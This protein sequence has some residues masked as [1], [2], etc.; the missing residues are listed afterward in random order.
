MADWNS[1]EALLMKQLGTK[2][3]WGGQAPGGFDCS[4][5][6]QWAY[7][8]NGIGL[9]RTTYNQINIGAS[10]DIGNLQPGDLVFFDTE[11]QNAGPDHV[12]IYI[13]GGKFIHAPHTGDVVKISSLADPYYQNRFFAGRRIPG[14]TGA[15]PADTAALTT[16]PQAQSTKLDAATLAQEYGLS[17]ALLTSDSGL[18]NLFNEAVAN[19]WTPDV[20]TAK[21]KESNWWKSNSETMRQALDMQK[22]D[23][24]TFAATMDA[25]REKARVAAVQAGAILDDKH[26]GDL[27]RNIVA[28]GWSDE[29][30]QNYLGQYIKFNDKHVLGGQA[31]AAYAQ[32]RQQAYAQ[33]INISDNQAKN[34]AAYVVSGVRSMDQVMGEINQ[35]AMGAFP[36]FADQIA[37]GATM[38]QVIDPYRQV[39]AKTLGIADTSISPF[40]PKIRQAV[41]RIGQDGQPDPMSLDDFT[42]SLKNTSEW[43]QTPQAIS[44]TLQIGHQVLKDMGLT[45]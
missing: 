40:S 33:G 25:A 16:A 43:R 23:P 27:A 44:S 5:L 38:D 24:A 4:G 34:Y 36:A 11:P 14:V 31:G 17:Y 41:N 22:S 18:K 19:Q 13:G 6:V 9:P 21:L 32:I 29:Q 1:I 42:Q 35:Q 10:V 45:I 28:L 15:G 2:Y 30:V 26:V 12:G 3:V 7:G 8:Q 37:A 39:M 20:F